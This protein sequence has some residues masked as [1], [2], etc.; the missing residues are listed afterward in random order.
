[1]II[2]K[3]KLNKTKSGVIKKVLVTIEDDRIVFPLQSTTPLFV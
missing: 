2:A 1:M 3:H